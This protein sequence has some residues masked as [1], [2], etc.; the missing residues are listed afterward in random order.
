MSEVPSIRLEGL[1]GEI[2]L[3]SSGD[4]AVAADIEVPECEGL[5]RAPL[6]VCVDLPSLGETAL[7]AARA[8]LRALVDAPR[9]SAGAGAADDAAPGGGAAGGAPARPDAPGLGLSAA[10]APGDEVE[11][12]LVES[13]SLGGGLDSSRGSRASRAERAGSGAQ[14]VR[15]VTVDHPRRAPRGDGGEALRVT[16]AGGAEALT[17]ARVILGTGSELDCVGLEMMRG[18][19]ERFALPTVG[20]LPVLSDALQWGDERFAVVGA[21]ASLQVGPD[22]GNLMG[23]RRAAEVCA[24]ELGVFDHLEQAGNELSN[25]FDVFASDSE[26]DTSDASDDEG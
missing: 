19:V 18:V 13:G 7:R 1:F 25:L 11:S 5:A 17:A 24:A 8:T 10:S 16:F 9:P 2:P 6:I 15:F 22:A 3:R 26:D 4:F 20:G 23:A 12:S 21:L 14:W